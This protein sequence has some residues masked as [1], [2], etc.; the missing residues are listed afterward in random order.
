MTPKELNEK[1]Y[2]VFLWATNYEKERI[3][4]PIIGC[5]HGVI[6][7]EEV[8]SNETTFRSMEETWLTDDI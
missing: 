6:Y 7:M 4:E 2:L 1:M 8:T 3:P 5:D